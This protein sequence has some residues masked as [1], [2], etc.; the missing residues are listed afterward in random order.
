MIFAR[1]KAAEVPAFHI[2]DVAVCGSPL[3]LCNDTDMAVLINLLGFVSICFSRLSPTPAF[4]IFF[5]VFLI[6][7]LVDFLSPQDLY[8][9]FY[10]L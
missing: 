7:F 9:G 5:L 8:F 6:F 3:S 4:P 2:C 10:N 1:F